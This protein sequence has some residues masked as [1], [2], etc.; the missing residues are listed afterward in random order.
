MKSLDEYRDPKFAKACTEELEAFASE[1]PAAKNILLATP[2][3][4]DVASYITN[5][6]YSEDNL[7][8]VG[9]SL[10]A[11]GSSLTQELDMD[12]CESITLDTGKGRIY[13]RAIEHEGNSLVLLIQT[14]K[15]GMLAQIL[16]GAS[17]LAERLREKLADS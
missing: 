5:D 3:G 11:L 7:A 1:V 13:I 14:G 10:F 16:H 9:S 8:A 12:I 15:R 2:D 4:F 17:K 6:D